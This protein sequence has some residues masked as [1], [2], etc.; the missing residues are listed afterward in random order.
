M[1]DSFKVDDGARSGLSAGVRVVD[2]G[3]WVP[4]PLACEIVAD[5]GADVIRLFTLERSDGFSSIHR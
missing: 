4:R 3:I 1:M 2:P 5:W